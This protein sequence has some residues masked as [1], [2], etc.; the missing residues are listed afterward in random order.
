MFR[1]LLGYRVWIQ[2][3][4]INLQILPLQLSNTSFFCG[5]LISGICSLIFVYVHRDLEV[6][7]S[8]EVSQSYFTLKG[9]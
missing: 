1:K 4:A 8:H 7:T 9:D 6:H 5:F 2:A 3:F